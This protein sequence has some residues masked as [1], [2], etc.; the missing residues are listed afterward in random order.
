MKKIYFIFFFLG[1]FTFAQ[2]GMNTLISEGLNYSY[3]FQNSK[4]QNSFKQ[5][6]KKYPSFPHGYH[7]YS[8]LYL[9]KY[10]SN[11][12]KEDLEL[13]L[14]YSDSAIAKGKKKLYENEKDAE[15][16]YIIGASYGC[17]S[18]AL[19]KSE[20]YL[21]MIWATR[22]SESYLEDAL[23]NNSELYDA[24]VGLGLFKFA[25]SRVPSAF[26]WAL[27]VI[28]FDPDQDEGL[29]LL[30][31][32]AQKGRFAK[33]EAKYYLA[34]I[35]SEYFQ[36]YD[37]SEKL[38]RGLNNE[39]P[40]NLLFLYSLAVNEMKRRNLNHAEKLLLKINS[41]HNNL[42]PQINAFTVFLLGDINFR[43]NNFKKAE[44]YYKSFIEIAPDYNYTGIANLRR[45][46][47]LLFEGDDNEAKISF[48]K[49]RKGNTTLDDDAYAA[50]K[51]FLWLKNSPNEIDLTLIRMENNLENKKYKIVFDSLSL[52][53]DSLKNERH[54]AYARI[55]LSDAAFHL[56]KYD[57]ALNFAV[58]SF[59]HKI[60]EESWIAP[61]GYVYSAKALIEKKNFTRAKEFLDDAEKLSDY[62]YASKIKSMIA[63]LRQKILVQK[64]D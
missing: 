34:Q 10:L 13:F 33:V 39:Y 63:S 32:T 3:N 17:R 9:W 43:R 7:Y 42:Y 59:Q 40:E 57:D 29:R 52:L 23:E 8:T 50:K 54:I 46:I 22:Q 16:Q 11:S 47:S 30:N 6:I 31:L 38:L 2:N 56:K 58:L 5:I 26:K 12:Q 44:S 15:I 28:G 53:L 36:D 45:G 14:A 41:L 35:Y 51:G 61:T 18:I 37:S 60:H 1:T 64:S 4:A 24:Y 25:L 62:D 55:L 48:E 20:S 27:S 21:E 19:G 49:A